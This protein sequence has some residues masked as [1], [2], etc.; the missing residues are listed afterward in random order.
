MKKH[1]TPRQLAEAIGV[2]ES[3][4]KRW[5]DAGRLS[6]SRTAGG[7]RRIQFAEAIRFIR[8][9]G[10]MVVQ[11][12]ALG[13]PELD[14]MVISGAMAPH[15]AD[16]RLLEFLLAG[17]DR[18]AR[19]L[20]LT[21]FLGGMPIATICDG[22]IHTAMDHLGELWKQGDHGI[23]LEHR[24][25]DICVQALNQVRQ[26]FDPPE[27]APLAIGGGGPKDPTLIPTIAA[28]A[29]LNENGMRVHN[30]GPD[31]P[32]SAL[33]LAALDHNA[34]LVYLGFTHECDPD[35]IAGQVQKLAEELEARR[36]WLVLGGRALT[37]LPQVKGQ[38]V[39]TVS[40]MSQL[41]LVVRQAFP[42]IQPNEDNNGYSTNNNNGSATYKGQHQNN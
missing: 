16:Q 35:L 6:A 41:A 4:L 22:P 34:S 19:G 39:R 23:Y 25:V 32:I 38:L 15:E 12:D 5:A 11:P 7:H 8:E 21:L 2:S 18:E 14:H 13:I 28:A 9:S 26:M 3:S 27:N 20:I 42:G 10:A 17:R 24:A 30:I 40:S 37:G 36:T 33:R 29:T 31:V 1:V